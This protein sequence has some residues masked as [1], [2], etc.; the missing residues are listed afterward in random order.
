MNDPHHIRYV[1]RLEIDT[2]K[3]DQC[4]DSSA[5]GLIYAYSYYLDTMAIQWD[6]LILG[7]YEAV[8]PLTWKKKWGIRY[9]YQPPFT[10]QL[11]V[12]S[13]APL[14]EK[15]INQFLEEIKKYFSFAEIYLNYGNYHPGLLVHANYILD[16]GEGYQMLSSKYHKH[17]KRDLKKVARYHYQYTDVFDLKKAIALSQSLYGS[18]IP[19]VQQADYDRFENLCRLAEKNSWM[20][21]RAVN[22]PDGNLLAV[23]LLLIGLRRMH[24]IMSITLPEGRNLEANHF[25]IDNLIK[26]FA[27][28]DFILDF[29]GSDIAGIARFYKHFD[30]LDQPYYF[31]RHNNL[32][33]PLKW[34]K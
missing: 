34:L 8:M 12:F 22:G 26:E 14:P 2:F 21:L 1:R 27:G 7:D 9:L 24:L 11:G 6:A 17:L 5:N 10:Q 29:E 32:P 33:W 15:R 19:H 30:S 3:W 13:A 20:V 23:A 16:M 18:R 4:I 31:H 25:L 28:W